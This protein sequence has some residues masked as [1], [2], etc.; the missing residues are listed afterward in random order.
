MAIAIGG[1]GGGGGAAASSSSPPSLL[2][3]AASSG[4]VSGEYSVHLSYDD[5]AQNRD[6]IPAGFKGDSKLR[7]KVVS[8]KSNTFDI[9]ASSK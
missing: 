1:G 3:G 5:G 8:G 2:S 9:D 7:F 4:A 6:P